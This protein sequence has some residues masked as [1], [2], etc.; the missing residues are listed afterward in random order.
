[1][2]KFES[3]GGCGQFVGFF[4][5]VKVLYRFFQD[6]TKK[7]PHKFYYFILF[8]RSGGEDRKKGSRGSDW[9]VKMKLAFCFKYCSKLE[10]E[11]L[12]SF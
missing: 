12:Q 5:T 9:R 1:M 4:H 7:V 11:N 8:E 3:H 2:T 6:Q 10:V